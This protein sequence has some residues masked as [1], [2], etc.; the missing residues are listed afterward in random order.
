MTGPIVLTPVEQILVDRYKSFKP[1]YTQLALHK[2][3]KDIVFINFYGRAV[4]SILLGDKLLSNKYEPIMKISRIQQLAKEW[5]Y[6]AILTY[7][8]ENQVKRILFSASIRTGK[9]ADKEFSPAKTEP[10]IDRI[11]TA[12]DGEISA[13]IFSYM[14]SSALPKD[15][16]FQVLLK[17]RMSQCDG[18]NSIE[19]NGLP[20]EKE[21]KGEMLLDDQTPT[22]ILHTI[23]D[24]FGPSTIAISFDCFPSF[25]YPKN[26]LDIASS[27]P[28]PPSFPAVITDFPLTDAAIAP[29][30]T[31]TFAGAAA[32]AAPAAHAA[33]AATAKA[34]DVSIK[35]V[36]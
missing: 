18:L 13:C 29:M 15:T 12:L 11:K 36:E 19:I 21:D 2:S 30:P 22:F 34:G 20:L 23:E 16:P 5:S 17:D 35:K 31:K 32:P 28:V 25:N 10:S 14:N 6:Q 9:I 24:K 1:T 3:D 7:R 27:L 4:V 33:L 26:I 8:V